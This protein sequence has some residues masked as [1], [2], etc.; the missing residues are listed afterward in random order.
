[1]YSKPSMTVSIIPEKGA[2]EMKKVQRM[3]SILVLVIL[4]IPT[5]SVLAKEG[6]SMTI[7]GP[8]IKG[9]VTLPQSDL[10][11]S[12]EDTGFFGF[13]DNVSAIK[14][15]ANL[16]EGYNI[17]W[18]IIENAKPVPVIEM[19]YYPAEKG[20]AGYVHYTGRIQGSAI[21]PVDEWG[22]LPLSADNAFRRLMDANKITLQT[23]VLSTSA[24]ES[25]KQPQT[26]PEVQSANPSIP[27][28][29]PTQIPYA[30]IAVVAIIL[31]VGAGLLLRKRVT[32]Q[33]SV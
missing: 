31:A 32:G 20:V 15:P 13:S 25:V 33:R 4:V 28:T 18:S 27:V 30:T 16:G 2:L 26:Q 23:A 8:G 3:I 12:L 10:M 22:Q 7:R 5:M 29:A 24:A 21:Q 17:T 9:E 1:M 11:M 6:M 19:V 14:P